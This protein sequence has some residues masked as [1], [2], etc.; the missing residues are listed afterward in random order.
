MIVSICLIQNTTMVTVM[1]LC[2]TCLTSTEDSDKLI[3]ITDLD[4]DG[5]SLLE[6]LRTCFPEEL[7]SYMLRTVVCPISA[8][9]Q[10]LKNPTNCH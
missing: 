9:L 2:Y 6:K 1:N 4:S 5:I 8:K 10:Y 3:D 7:V